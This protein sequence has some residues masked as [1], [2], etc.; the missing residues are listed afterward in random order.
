MLRA[1]A[2]FRSELT[3]ILA[4]LMPP[5]RL[6]LEVSMSSGLRIGDVLQLR[7]D[8]LITA[9]NNRISV[10][11]QKTGKLKRFRLPVELFDLCLTQCGK[12]FVF[13]HRLDYRRHRTRQ[14]VYKDLR[15]ACVLMRLKQHLSP[16]SARKAYAVA[17]YHKCRDIKKVQ[18]LLNHSDEAVTM[19]YAMADE[20]TARRLAGRSVKNDHLPS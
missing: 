17:E 13:E 2:V 11:E 7:T 4:A 19:I 16:H 9:K 20:L 5:N 6:A 12:V 18:K 14:A 15:R 1:D 8:Q 10:R 3:H